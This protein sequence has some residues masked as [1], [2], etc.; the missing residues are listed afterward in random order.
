[1]QRSKRWKMTKK[2]QSLNSVWKS[3]QMKKS[4]MLKSFDK[5]DLEDLYKLVNAK[6]DSTRLVEDLDLLLW[7]D[8]ETMF[9]P[10]VEDAV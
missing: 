2:Q 9:E 5:G 10:H 8:L 4:Q 7:G 6:Y 1:M 3:F